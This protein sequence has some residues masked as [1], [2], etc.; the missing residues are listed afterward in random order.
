M[1]RGVKRV[2]LLF[3]IFF[4]AK[5]AAAQQVD[6]R[7][8]VTRALP[9]LQK[10][11]ATFVEQRAC[12][13]CH[14][15]ALPIM[16]LHMARDRGFAI[17]AKVLS[18]VEDKTFRTL[19][20][21][22][23]LDEAIQGTN[24]SDPTPNDSLLLMSAEAA[25]VTR[26]LTTEVIATRMA[27]WQRDG[28]WITSDFRPP[29]SSSLFTTT[30]T[31]I[32]A[33]RAY[34]PGELNAER[35]TAIASARQW[36]LTTTPPRSTEDWSFLVMGLVWAGAGEKDIAGAAEDLV[37]LQNRDGG[38]SQLPGYESDAYSSGEA[39]FALHEAG[40]LFSSPELQRGL[41][42]LVST[43]A[44]DG[45]WHVKTRMLSPAEVSPP[46][47]KTG[48][49]YGKDEFLSYAGSSWAM[50]AL[51]SALPQSG[52]G[53]VPE[54]IAPGPTWI[55]TALFG[56]PRN[57]GVLLSEGLAPNSKTANGTTLLMMSATDPEKIRL[58]VARG[59]DVKARTS[60]GT[61]ALTIAASYRGTTSAV[62]ALL[63]AGAEVHAP[64][65]VRTRR[66]PLVF[67]SMT[68]D[69]ENVKLL[70]SRGAKP[71]AEALS[72]AVTFGNADIVRAFIDAGAD[73]SIKE[74]SGVNLLHW[75]TITNR[76]SVIPVLA[77]AHVPINDTDDNGFTPLM[78]AATID[79][80]D[81][82]TLR[83][84]LKA[85]ADRKIRNTDG[86]TAL[87]LAR[88][89]KHTQHIDALK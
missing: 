26:D 71:D 57:F 27:R 24:A 36:L 88:R 39:L 64:E 25:G 21:A 32:R 65:G 44:K 6:V 89:F 52:P 19:R 28:H 76:A 11:A 74:S 77:A 81:T 29:H 34:M 68:G 56:S 12:F 22:N 45:S 84:L 58:L 46:Y 86:K 41:K 2:F 85:G 4:A 50:M 48:F 35:D 60:N 55:R 78:Y 69:L 49:P 8:A 87:D 79:Q 3:L 9:I 42:F 15:N 80:G 54:S 23:A 30:A 14:H 63:D 18:A 59:V 40:V 62:R 47:F 16:T 37:R 72:E 83:E 82:A 38:W 67:A 13:S 73:A 53:I 70:L 66:S 31:A 61:D 7:P 17:D 5:F 75:A 10:S 51:L 1:I 33:M 20:G 43:Q